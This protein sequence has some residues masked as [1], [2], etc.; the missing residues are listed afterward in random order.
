MTAPGSWLSTVLQVMVGGVVDRTPRAAGFAGSSNSSLGLLGF[1]FHDKSSLGRLAFP[2][3][4]LVGLVSPVS[5]FS[6]N[7]PAFLSSRALVRQREQFRSGP[8][9]A[10]AQLF[11]HLGVAY[12]RVESGDDGMGLDVRDGVQHVAEALGVLAQ[13]FVWLL[14]QVVE[15]ADSARALV[16]PL[17]RANEL[18]AQICPGLD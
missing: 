7:Q 9:R 5:S 14:E 10:H 11:P 15:I 17:E 1:R 8:D 3:L 12:V 2:G 18:V 6:R 13:S 4:L 16:S